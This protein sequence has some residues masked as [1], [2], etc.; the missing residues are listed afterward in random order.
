MSIPVQCNL[1]IFSTFNKF[2]YLKIGHVCI[3]FTAVMVLIHL[4]FNL[5]ILLHVWPLASIPKFKGESINELYIYKTDK[6]N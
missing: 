3:K 2:S 5:V 1:K 4:L 6:A